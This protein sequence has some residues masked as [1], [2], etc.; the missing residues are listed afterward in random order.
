MRRSRKKY[1]KWVLLGWNAGAERRRRRDY[2]EGAEKYPK[3]VWLGFGFGFGFGWFGL[4]WFGFVLGASTLHS[5]TSVIPAQAGI[6]VL[7]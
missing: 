2:A 6:Y 3:W 1:Q 7:F 5:L 4:V